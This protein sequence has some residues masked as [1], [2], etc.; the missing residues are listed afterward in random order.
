MV[1]PDDFCCC[2]LSLDNQ[3]ELQ[4]V[5]IQ[6]SILTCTVFQHLTRTNVNTCS[7]L[8]HPWPAQYMLNDVLSNLG[9]YTNWS[10]VCVYTLC[11]PENDDTSECYTGLRATVCVVLPSFVHRR[12]C[13]MGKNSA[14][15]LVAL[16][17]S[18]LF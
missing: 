5:G 10:S 4:T 16:F 1:K 17:S 9:T 13:Q 18:H 12:Q 14:R 11:V 7:I 3:E 6:C 15:L 8:L 2:F